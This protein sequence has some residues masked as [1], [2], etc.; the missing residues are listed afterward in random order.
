TTGR[1]TWSAAASSFS[2]GSLSP[3]F[4]LPDWIRAKSLLATRSAAGYRRRGSID[5]MIVIISLS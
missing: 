5:S 2:V 1:E 4:R 3:A